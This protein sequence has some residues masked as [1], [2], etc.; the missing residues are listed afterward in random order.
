MK[1]IA[2]C[3]ILAI[4]ATATLGQNI[5]IDIVT[6]GNENN[7]EYRIDNIVE[8]FRQEYK[9]DC[10]EFNQIANIEAATN[11]IVLELWESE[12]FMSQYIFRQK[13]TKS[14]K[15]KEGNKRD[16]DFVA[17]GLQVRSMY[18]IY[19]R[20]YEKKDG[21]ILET[22]KIG[23]TFDYEIPSKE[24]RSKYPT[25]RENYKEVNEMFLDK[26][27]DR[28]AVQRNRALAEVD[29]LFK[30]SLTQLSTKLLLPAT[31]TGIAKE[32]ND[33]VKKANYEKCDVVEL[34][35][36]SFLYIPIV[37]AEQ[38][39]GESLYRK[40]GSCYGD[41]KPGVVG[42]RGG[43]KEL[44]PLLKSD[45]E[46]YIGDADKIEPDH[47]SKYKDEVTKDISFVYV[48]QV[49]HKYNEAERKH[50]ELM[51]QGSFLGYDDVKVIAHDPVAEEMNKTFAQSIYKRAE[52]ESTD[53]KSLLDNLDPADM[54]SG[55][56]VYVE[57]GNPKKS[58]VE[59]KKSFLGQKVDVPAGSKYIFVKFKYKSGEDTYEDM[60]QITGTKRKIGLNLDV[61][62]V[63]AANVRIALA[64]TRIQILGIEEEKKGKVKKVIVAGNI[65]L[66]G[67][68]KYEV[69]DKPDY[70]EK[71]KA[72]AELS[73]DDKLNTYVATAKVKKGD[74]TIK[75]LIESEKELY[76][77]ISS[78]GGGLLGKA[79]RIGSSSSYLPRGSMSYARAYGDRI[80]E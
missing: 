80:R 40:V 74:K 59:G 26:F 64:D 51:C 12:E 36:G 49:D 48:Y 69:Y 61:L 21:N 45:S 70:G 67:G 50:I 7:I 46:L 32:K 19:G 72:L 42:I 15:D 35:G 47:L 3:V 73:I 79:L 66:D 28:I 58:P 62:S 78:Q 44:M 68:D 29:T 23:G 1:Y 55:H 76:I 75:A 30:K 63:D 5:V 65:P 43:E 13:R 20:M 34:K 25:R 11:D 22:F 8:T 41:V 24:I 54:K 60:M 33:K 4:T 27:Q 17:T 14:V 18:E 9:S 39:G 56:V 16:V 31:L 10:I 2:I 52:G 53:E 71:T 6:Y 37:Q 57:I 77:D 38:I